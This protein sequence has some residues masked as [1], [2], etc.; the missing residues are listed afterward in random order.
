MLHLDRRH[1]D[2]PRIGALVEDLLQLLVQTL[3]L[4]QQVVQL[5][6]AQH[7]PQ[8]R[9]GE[10]RRRVVE[11]LDFDDRPPR[12]DHAEVQDRVHLDRD[13]VARDHVLRRHVEHDRPQADLD[14]AIDRREDENDAGALRLRQ[15]L[16]EAEDDAA[17]V[18]GQDLDRAD[19]VE[20][21]DER[22]DEQRAR[23]SMA[24]PQSLRTVSVNPS[25]LVMRTRAPSAI[26]SRRDRLPDFAVDGDTAECARFDGGQ[27]L[28][29]LAD[30]ARRRRSPAGCRW[31]ARPSLTRSDGDR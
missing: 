9:L 8:R 6:L 26:G 16:A 20:H 18:F 10:L 2:A 28:A 17:L 3:A 24:E 1:L 7:A 31:A 23:Y 12:I 15:Q 11:V 4:R 14:H 13:V 19:E 25:T 21:D 22:D 30:H 29:G 5:H 27:R